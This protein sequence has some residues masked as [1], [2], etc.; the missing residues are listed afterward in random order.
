MFTT[1]KWLGKQ[2]ADDWLNSIVEKHSLKEIETRNRRP[3]KKFSS[4]K[5]VTK[6][7]KDLWDRREKTE[8]SNCMA[9][10]PM[11]LSLPDMSASIDTCRENEHEAVSLPLCHFTLPPGTFLSVS[12]WWQMPHDKDECWKEGNKER[13]HITTHYSWLYVPLKWGV[14]S[15]FVQVS[16]L[17]SDLKHNELD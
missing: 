8:A 16:N 3:W 7:V 13:R 5:T 12:Y 9:S 2:G 15:H 11:I 1:F 17:N 6:L 4:V 10:G 14:V